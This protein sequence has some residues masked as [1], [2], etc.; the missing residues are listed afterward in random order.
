MYGFFKISFRFLKDLH[1]FG[2]SF[3]VS[4]GFHVGFDLGIL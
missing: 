3:R 2:V 4:V 1:F